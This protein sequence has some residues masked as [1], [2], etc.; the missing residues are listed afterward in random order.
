[1]LVP[2]GQQTDGDLDLSIVL[3]GEIGARGE[4]DGSHEGGE[5]AEAGTEH[6]VD[7]PETPL[8]QIDVRGFGNRGHELARDCVSSGVGRALGR[9]VVRLGNRCEVG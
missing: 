6:Q 9:D 1:M 2:L 7:V 8:G 5:L 3:L 4:V